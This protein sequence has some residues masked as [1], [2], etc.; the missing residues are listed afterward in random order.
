[1]DLARP[2]VIVFVSIILYWITAW[3][4]FLN[5]R[6]PPKKSQSL[7]VFMRTTWFP[8]SAQLSVF[9]MQRVNAWGSFNSWFLVPP[10]FIKWNGHVFQG[11]YRVKHLVLN[12]FLSKHLFRDGEFWWKVNFSGH[13]FSK[14]VNSRGHFQRISEKCPWEFTHFVHQNSQFMFTR[15]LP[16]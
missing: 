6:T 7:L 11:I 5:G 4:D 13:F 9:A 12:A 1:M 10:G 16:T 15:I 14:W 3:D 8:Y 2:V